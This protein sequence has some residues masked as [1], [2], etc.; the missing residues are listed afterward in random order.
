MPDRTLF[1]EGRFVWITLKQKAV[2]ELSCAVRILAHLGSHSVAMLFYLNNR[3]T[4]LHQPSKA[5][6][7]GMISGGSSPDLDL[8]RPYTVFLEESQ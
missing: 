3:D 4:S 8:L 7:D 5:L 6:V 1:H 2:S